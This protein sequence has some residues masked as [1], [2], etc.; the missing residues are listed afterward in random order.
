M[1]L[2]G[3]VPNGTKSRDESQRVEGKRENMLFPFIT[4]VHEV[5]RIL[6]RT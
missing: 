5:N 2:P 4:S 6:V 1:G 3:V